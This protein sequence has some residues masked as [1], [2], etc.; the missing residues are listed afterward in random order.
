MT[1]FFTP[2][3]ANKV[4]PKIRDLVNGAVETKKKLE[5]A[6]DKERKGCLDRLSVLMGKINVTGVEL[7]DLETG[8]VDFPAMRFNEPVYLCWKLGENEILYWHEVSAGFKGR[9]VL[10]PQVTVLP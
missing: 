6:T 2:E 1:H 8:L 10:K 4:L 3:E 9:K 7:K 5:Y